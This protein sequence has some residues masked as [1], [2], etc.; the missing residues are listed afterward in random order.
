MNNAARIGALTLV[1]G[2]CLAP[3]NA[4]ADQTYGAD[5]N[6]AD[7]QNQLEMTYC[8]GEALAREDARLNF[9]YRGAMERAQNLESDEA[10]RLLRQVQRA[11]IKYRDLACAS[12]AA[13]AQGGSISGQLYLGC[14]T[15]LTRQRAAGLALFLDVM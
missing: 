2:F 13:T 11:W 1:V 14:K 10:A 8:E 9:A 5:V 4:Q 15:Y 6:C 12:E 7:P 3:R